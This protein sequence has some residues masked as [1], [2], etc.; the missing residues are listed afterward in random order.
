[1][2]VQP[3]P[4]HG[5]QLR[6]IAARYGISVERLTDFSANI[7]PAGPSPSVQTAIRR[8]LE[9]PATLATYPDLEL[10]ELKQTIANREG[11]RPENIVVANGFVPILGAALRSLKIERCL[12]PV[13]SFGEYRRALENADVFVRPYHLSQEKK[14]EYEIDAILKAL[15]D[16]S[17]D[18]ILLANPQNPSG[19]LCSA[20]RMRQLIR[21]ASR[22]SI[23][24]LLDEAF[25]DYC[26]FDSLTRLAMEQANVIVFRS[27][28]KFFAIPGLRVAYAV[29]RSATVQ[30]MNR[31][32]APWPITSFASNALCAALQDGPYA[33]ES[34][35]ANN[36]RRLWLEQE[37]ARLKIATYSARA[38]FLLLRF[39]AEV[40]VTLLWEKMI[41]EEQIVLRSC[42][43]FEGLAPG[44]LRIAVRSEPENE[45]L[46][47]GLVECAAMASDISKVDTDRHINPGPPE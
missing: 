45:R 9:D 11:L 36:R 40:D 10:V 47:R 1:M 17:C 32:I 43:N 18:A 21:M 24:V 6:E 41:V 4:I 20:E 35:V 3:P 38:N 14:F 46:I 8:A 7:N 37:L 19:A 12:L 33:E 30:A 26:P 29:G 15:L 25:I 28:T 22:H 16:H 23:T 31:F 42:T 27:V 13:P 5:G 39:S 2:N 34:R 44:H